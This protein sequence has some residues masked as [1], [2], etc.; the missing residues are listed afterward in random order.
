MKLHK[1][2]NKRNERRQA[3]ALEEETTNEESKM[4]YN[5]LYEN[6]N[7]YLGE[8]V[9]G[10]KFVEPKAKFRPDGGGKIPDDQD[11]DV[12]KEDTVP[13]QMATPQSDVDRQL[14]KGTDAI[15]K[16][17]QANL[18]KLKQMQKAFMDDI[19][20]EDPGNDAEAEKKL[21]A[22][23]KKAKEITADKAEKLKQSDAGKSGEQESPEPKVSAAL[24]DLID[25]AG[26]TWDKI[27]SSAKDKSLQKAMDYVEEF[28]VAERLK[29]S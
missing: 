7:K 24:L 4:K 3:G 11:W 18:E 1:I 21:A 25:K 6:W 14:S 23:K 8:Y 22:I 9:K 16:Q 12:D 19:E 27:R 17:Y 5:K 20:D 28:A 13:L 2:N 15:E 26:D 10:G 29:K